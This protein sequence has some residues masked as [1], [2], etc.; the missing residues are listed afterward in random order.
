MVVMEALSRMLSTTVDREI[1]LGFLVGFRNN[2]ELLLSRFRFVDD[3]L[4]ICEGIQIIFVIYT[5]F[6]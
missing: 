5:S 6:S 1:L 4:I 2:N 3:T